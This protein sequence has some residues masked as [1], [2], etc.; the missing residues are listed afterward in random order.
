MDIILIELLTISKDIYII[1]HFRILDCLPGPLF[2]PQPS[3]LPL[4]VQEPRCEIPP[5][6]RLLSL[7]L[8]PSCFAFRSSALLAIE[9]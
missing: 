6:S 3:S 9:F 4:Q 1:Y 5:A 2:P 8:P 7:P